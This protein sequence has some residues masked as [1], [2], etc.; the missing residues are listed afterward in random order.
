MPPQ[1]SASLAQAPPFATHAPTGTQCRFAGLAT[2]VWT[3]QT[4]AL[5]APQQSWFDSHSVV[6]DRVVDAAMH[7]SCTQYAFELPEIHS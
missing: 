3:L 7:A 2:G 5:G 6:V 1:Q 4:P